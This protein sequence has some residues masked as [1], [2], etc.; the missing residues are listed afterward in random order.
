VSPKC[1]SHIITKDYLF[2][3]YISGPP[4]NKVQPT[5]S[6][7]LSLALSLFLPA[8]AYPVL[9]CERNEHV[10][11]RSNARCLLSLSSSSTIV[12]GCICSSVW[13]IGSRFANWRLII[14]RVS[15]MHVAYHSVCFIV[16]YLH[17]RNSHQQS[18]SFF[19]RSLSL[20]LSLSSYLLLLILY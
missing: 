12:G 6:G 14:A 17:Q 15:E 20:S 7:S 8:A 16:C 11:V 9:T 5:A 13:T 1:T 10:C 18:S 19:S 3:L 2:A 4:P